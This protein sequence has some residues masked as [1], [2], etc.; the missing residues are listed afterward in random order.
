MNNQEFS[1][2][3]IVNGNAL[4]EFEY[5][6]RTYVQAIPDENYSIQLVLPVGKGAFGA[7]LTVDGCLCYGIEAD[8]FDSESVNFLPRGMTQEDEDPSE[9]ELPGPMVGNAIEGRFRFVV[10]SDQVVSDSA[11]GVIR[12]EYF[13][14]AYMPTRS[15]GSVQSRSSDMQTVIDQ[16]PVDGPELDYSVKYSAGKKICSVE[17]YYASAQ[18]LK[19]NGV[20]H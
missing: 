7:L 8:D 3:I 9:N 4:P 19:D 16:G 20:I 1:L 12:V 11:T 10:N 13:E 17:V 18:W 6:G 15:S 14:N 5:Q 2:N